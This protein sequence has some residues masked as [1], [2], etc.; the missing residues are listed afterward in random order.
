MSREQQQ[1]IFEPFVQA[2]GSITRKYGGTGLGLS[3]S[4]R[5][6][7]L[8]GGRIWVESEL[9]KGSQFHFTVSIVPVCVTKAL[10]PSAPRSGTKTL[11]VDDNELNRRI[12]ERVL[13]RWGMEV[14]VVADGPAALRIL[15]TERVAGRAF[16]LI[17]LDAHMPGMDGFAVAAAIQADAGEV[18]PAIMMLTS[19]DLATDVAH[20]RQLGIQR[21]L[22]KPVSRT[23]L[24][25]AI[26]QVLSRDASPLRPKCSV[27]DY[28]DVPPLRILLA[29]DNPVNERVAVRLLEKQGHLVRS[30][31]NGKEVLMRL[32]QETFDIILMDVQMP[33]MDGIQCTR[34]IRSS[35]G[36]A[37]HIPIVA[38]TAHAMQADREICRNAGMDGYISKPI[39][40]DELYQALTEVTHA[41]GRSSPEFREIPTPTA[42]TAAAIPGQ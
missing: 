29:E 14:H 27:P 36:P 33:L 39:A 38:M 34:T 22:V 10:P 40:R 19:V 20:C 24:K 26:L 6:V 42:D 7:E 4:S 31:P 23:D 15:R 37:Q 41:G 35:A 18:A 13:R 2:D 21:Y 17:L 1:V 32:E 12:L 9:G 30:V 5:L 28:T 3:I 8:M 25:A 11:I 16:E